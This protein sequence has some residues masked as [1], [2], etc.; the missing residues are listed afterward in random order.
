MLKDSGAAV[1]LLQNDGKK[2]EYDNVRII[3]LDELRERRSGNLPQAAG[4]ENFAYMIYTS[5]T[6]GRPKGVMCHNRG[7]VNRIEWM[8][9][10]YPIGAGDAILQKTTY[11]FDVSVWEIIWWSLVGAK[12]VLLEPGG[13]RDPE[14]ICRRS[15]ESR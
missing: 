4:P 2:K 1:M 9:R 11:T 7:L 10:R 12:V 13:E 3:Y 15:M 6:T 5:G 14:M 8:Q